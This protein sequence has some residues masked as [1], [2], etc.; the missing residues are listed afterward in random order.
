MRKLQALVR[1]HQPVRHQAS[2]LS[3]G[4]CSSIA[5]SFKCFRS[6]HKPVEVLMAVA[7]TAWMGTSHVGLSS[8]YCRFSRHTP[9]GM[10]RMNAEIPQLRPDAAEKL[11]VEPQETRVEYM[12]PGLLKCS[13]SD[14]RSC[15]HGS[16]AVHPS[17]CQGREGFAA[18]LHHFTPHLCHFTPPPPFSKALPNECWW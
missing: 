4:C 7:A 3:S 16:L 2:W 14:A 8:C 15:S 1:L 13:R 10:D 9:D 5:C 18:I 17:K 11:S 6:C 12:L